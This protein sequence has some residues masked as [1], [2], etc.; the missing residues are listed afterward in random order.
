MTR[1]PVDLLQSRFDAL[2]RMTEGI[3]SES[4]S[5]FA[6][7]FLEANCDQL[8]FRGLLQAIRNMI[9]GLS[10]AKD[11]F[12]QIVS[13][14]F[15]DTAD[16]FDAA[17]NEIERIKDAGEKAMAQIAFVRALRETG[18]LKRAATYTNCYE[19]SLENIEQPSN[20]DAISQFIESARVTGELA[21]FEKAYWEICDGDFS[22]RAQYFLQLHHA[23]KAHL[24]P[25]L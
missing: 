8:A 19:L 13:A 7:W 21:D 15:E 18:R 20:S 24:K 23:I 9:F 12:V 2:I 14:C 4:I 16:A 22:V 1:Q 17:E 11:P 5:P 10:I 6:I 3:N 25:L